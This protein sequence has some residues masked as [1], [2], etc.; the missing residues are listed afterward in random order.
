MDDLNDRI[1]AYL[2]GRP[3]G[4]SS[5]EITAEVMKLRGGSTAIFER[6]V[7]TALGGDNRFIK[8]PDGRWQIVQK[9]SL[10]PMIFTV[11]SLKADS[12]RNRMLEIGA[13]RLAGGRRAGK[14]FR[15]VTDN[16]GEDGSGVAEDVVSPRQA[17]VELTEFTAN[18]TWV[19]DDLRGTLSLL[20]WEARRT[21]APRP[22]SA[23]LSLR[24]LGR[25]MFLHIRV[26]SAWGMASTLGL[27]H[28]EQGRSDR[29]AEGLSSILFALLERCRSRGKTRL[30]EILSIQEPD[31]EGV[32]F[33]RYGFDRPFLRSLPESPGVYK[34]FDQ[35]GVVIYVGKANSLRDRVGCYFGRTSKRS[36]KM[37]RFLDR[38]YDLRVEV[39]GSELEA[40]LLEGRLIRR[41]QPEFNAQLQVHERPSSLSVRDQV[42]VLSSKIEGC[43]ELFMVREGKGLRQIRARQDL[44]DIEGVR[45][46]FEDHFGSR[47]D[48]A[49]LSEEE[50]ADAEIGKSWLTSRGEGINRLDVSGVKNLE[51]GLRL[52]KDYIARCGPPGSDRVIY[53]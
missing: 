14:F 48:K 37:I 41:Y 8:A 28:R 12:D 53:V 35:M 6:I 16:P 27:S 18:S 3:S 31:L 40:L 1:Q 7:R 17:L 51:D 23:G 30:E 15:S 45:V 43:V 19:A 9:P 33:S 50:K 49:G 20:D 38:L 24:R 39:V 11:I 52:L 32:D 29:E 25:R 26:R 46:V 34:M 10:N 47:P 36:E 21:E 5:E 44:S 13:V 22:P 4:A 42:F 2:K